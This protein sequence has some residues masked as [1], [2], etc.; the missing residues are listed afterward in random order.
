MDRH[1]CVTAYVFNPNDRRFLMVH[2]RKLNMWVPPGGHVDP[3]EIPDNAAVRETLEETGVSVRLIDRKGPADSCLVAPFGIQRNIIKE[4]LHEHLD[5]IY[6][7]VPESDPAQA[8]LNDRESLGIGW[9]TL[10][11]IMSPSF[12]TFVTVRQWSSYFAQ[13]IL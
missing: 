1:F 2:H 9:F 10:D 4:G 5:L 3:N 13:E 8:V 7:A 12:A 11:E 6:L